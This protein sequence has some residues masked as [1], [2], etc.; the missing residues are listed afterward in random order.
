MTSV[1]I[2]LERVQT[3]WGKE[4]G[5]SGWDMWTFIPQM[6]GSVGGFEKSLR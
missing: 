3:D 1:E 2:C 5:I 4:P 6:L